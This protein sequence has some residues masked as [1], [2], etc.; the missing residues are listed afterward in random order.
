MSSREDVNKTFSNLL[1]A[2]PIKWEKVKFLLTLNPTST[3]ESLRRQALKKA[4]LDIH[5]PLSVLE[6]LL[7]QT[8]VDLEQRMKL[9]LSAV[10]CEN[11]CWVKTVIYNNVSVLYTEAVRGR[12]HTL[13]HLVC[14]KHGWNEQVRF[15]LK[16]TLENRDSESSSHN[17]MFELNHKM[18]SPLDLALE[19]GCDLQDV[20]LHLQEEFPLYFEQNIGF[21]PEIIAKHCNTMIL[22]E[23]LIHSHPT[24]VKASPENV[25]PLHHACYY[26]NAHMIQTM[27]T[28]YSN[29][30]ER[31]KKLIKRLMVPNR[32]VKETPFGYLVPALGRMDSSNAFECIRTIMSCI[33]NFHLLHLII[34]KHWYDLANDGTCL[35]TLTRI[36]SNLEGICFSAVDDH[37]KTVMSLLISKMRL[38]PS[39]QAIDVL[40]YMLMEQN[41]ATSRDGKGRLPLHVSCE[42][43]ILWSDGVKEI[44]DANISALEE[45]DN[46][47]GLLPFALSATSRLCDLNTVYQLFRY[48]PG[49]I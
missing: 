31:R 30:G 35:N 7:K 49:M 38:T 45:V 42:R 28:Y 27:L 6:V 15:I 11:S 21:L 40:N 25:T 13:L 23:D 46:K 48:N 10:R 8:H 2:K 5:V 44:V 47:I 29:Q 4:C 39:K 17:G 32:T 16:E 37:G 26:Q 33:D 12:R 3:L 14:E 36:A 22:F 20:I 19:A 9:L 1:I 41:G 24:I 43:G 18:Q 34:E